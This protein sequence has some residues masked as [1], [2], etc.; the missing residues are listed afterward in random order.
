MKT[1][2]EQLSNALNEAKL[3]KWMIVDTDKN[4]TYIVQAESLEKAK[5][6]T[7]SDN[8]LIGWYLDNIL[9]SKDPVVLVDSDMIK[10][11]GDKKY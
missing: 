4:I 3:S 10:S 9:K 8:K 2:K 5:E 11:K 6:I 1:I 7:P